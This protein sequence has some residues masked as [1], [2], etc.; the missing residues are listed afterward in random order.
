MLGLLSF[1]AGLVYGSLNLES[2]RLR[3]LP[4]DGG[5]TLLYKNLAGDSHS[6]QYLEQIRRSRHF[7]TEAGHTRVRVHHEGGHMET[8]RRYFKTKMGGYS[9]SK[10]YVVLVNLTMGYEFQKLVD[11]VAGPRGD[12]PLWQA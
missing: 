9:K 12:K 2:L 5:S 7:K 3:F 1:S 11:K 8:R 6:R 10:V 4:V